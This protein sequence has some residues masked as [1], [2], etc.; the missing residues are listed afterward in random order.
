MEINVE[1]ISFYAFWC[2]DERLKKNKSS[3]NKSIS[4]T[5]SYSFSGNLNGKSH[6]KKEVATVKAE[7]N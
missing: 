7:T 4:S 6:W 3:I 5:R 2:L 1:E